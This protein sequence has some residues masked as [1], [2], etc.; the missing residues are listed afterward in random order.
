[1]NPSLPSSQQVPLDFFGS[2]L[3][4]W[5]LEK[6][7]TKTHTQPAL[8]ALCCTESLGS[9]SSGEFHLAAGRHCLC[10]CSSVCLGD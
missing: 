5:T 1:M 3:P 2:S 6:N 10:G 4:S 8:A 7:K 9:N